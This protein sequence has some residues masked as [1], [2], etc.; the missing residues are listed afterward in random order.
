MHA[1]TAFAESEQ[2]YEIQFAGAEHMYSWWTVFTQPGTPETIKMQY[3]N[4]TSAGHTVYADEIQI[5]A[6]NLSDDLTENTDWHYAA[7]TTQTAQT[8]SFVDRASITFTPSSGVNDWL[9]LGRIGIDH[10]PAGS[11]SNRVH[12]QLLEDGAL[13]RAELTQIPEDTTDQIQWPIPYVAQSLSEASHTYKLQSKDSVIG[14]A[15][16]ESSAVLAIDTSKFANVTFVDTATQIGPTVVVDTWAEANTI[17]HTPDATGDTL[18][19]GD[20]VVDHENTIDHW[21][22][23]IQV[24]GT[25]VPAGWDGGAMAHAYP[26]S[27]D[28]VRNLPLFVL[29]SVT[30]AGQALDLDY[31]PAQDGGFLTERTIIA[32]SMALPAAA[33]GGAGGI[34]AMLTVSD[35]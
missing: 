33:G 2:R 35:D 4:V 20:I 26:N 34:P 22:T 11:L 25:T 9:I 5:I 3:R 32:I 13:V 28:D 18:I 6:I 1:S 16:Y 31:Y 19:I 7:D 17:T 24:A 23:R 12:V 29:S 8:G 15:N 30:D 21:G 14:A 10:T 27:G